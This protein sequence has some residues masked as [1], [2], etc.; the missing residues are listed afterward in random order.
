MSRKIMENNNFGSPD[1]PIYIKIQ[2]PEIL[3]A[4]EIFLLIH[5]YSGNENSMS[6]FQS[7]IP[8][9]SICFSPRGI[10]EITENQF[11][12]VNPNLEMNNDYFS[13]KHSAI[14]LFDSIKK[15]TENNKTLENKKINLIGFSQG[16]TMCFV[17]SQLFPD[18]FYKIALL[19]GFLPNKYPGS[20]LQE[21]EQLNYF[22][23]HGT[24]DQIVHYSKA[25]EI[26]AFLTLSGAN[27]E[28]CSSKIAHKVS[29]ECLRRLKLFFLN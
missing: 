4:S 21:T 16:A 24:E 1:T 11:S 10:Y 23:S 12:W 8:Q 28:T 29:S 15:I 26:Q 6:I 7:V 14:A 5:G 13:F 2:Q 9:N 17:L 27:V 18:T 19:S 20:S 22:I 25:I 3:P